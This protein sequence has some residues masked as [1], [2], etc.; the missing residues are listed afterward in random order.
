MENNENISEDALVSALE[1]IIEVT[2]E[3]SI[4]RDGVHY[5]LL[6]NDYKMFNMQELKPIMDRPVLWLFKPKHITKLEYIALMDKHPTF[7]KILSESTNESLELKILNP[8]PTI[9]KYENVS[10]CISDVKYN[11]IFIFNADDIEEYDPDE[12]EE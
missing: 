8:V 9:P 12:D 4:I 3:L 5:D 1:S 7:V 10:V 6:I 2:P 11:D